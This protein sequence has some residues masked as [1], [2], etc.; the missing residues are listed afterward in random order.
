MNWQQKFITF[1]EMLEYGSH[2]YPGNIAMANL[3]N[4]TFVRYD[5]L[6]YAVDAISHQINALF[7]TDGRF[8]VSIF[9]ENSIEWMLIFLSAV[10]G[11]NII[12]PLNYQIKDPEEICRLIILADIKAV[13]VAKQFNELFERVVNEWPA[14]SSTPAPVI[15]SLEE[16]CAPAMKRFTESG[17]RSAKQPPRRAQTQGNT[18]RTSNVAETAAQGG[19]LQ[20]APDDYAV[21]LFTSGSINTKGV[22][23]SQRSILSN[24]QAAAELLLVAHQNEVFIAGLPLSHAYGL[25]CGFVPLYFGATAV[26]APTPRAIADNITASSVAFP[27][28]KLL[29][30]GV[31]ELARIMNQRILRSARG[32]PGKNMP[33]VR[34]FLGSIK[35]L[36]FLGMRRVNYF[37]STWFGIDLSGVFFK[38]IKAKFG[39]ELKIPIG[40]GPT[41]KVTEF[42]LRGVGILAHGGYGTTEMAP[43]LAANIPLVNKIRS[44]SV[45][46]VPNGMEVKIIDG[47]VCG[48]GPNMMLGY[49]NNDEATKKAMP[50]D[51]WYHTGDKGNFS[52][53]G[54]GGKLKPNDKPEDYIYTRA[55]DNYCLVLKGRVDNQFANHRGENIY[56]EVIES[57]LLKYPLINSCR[58]LES[59]PTHVMAHVFPDTEALE[60]KYGKSPSA[61][62]IKSVI[63][64]I[65]K[66]VN[67]QLQSGCQIDGFEIKDTDFDR[68][69][70]GKIKRN[71]N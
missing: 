38:P 55:D 9:S 28:K 57:L 42:G 21:L 30:A 67:L 70:F 32:G 45:G 29:T 39:N 4:K 62:T 47:E 1:N 40:G 35:Y 15:L 58:V 19:K 36:L 33:P 22:M 56:P 64:N 71:V 26:Y 3:V 51:G 54:F 23:H 31:P 66:Q 50:G 25:L 10:A 59:P 60:Q 43:L 65:V 8:V 16:A 27:D 44:G 18:T 41:D 49:L 68:N 14:D 11:N 63:S 48:R 69:A 34:K 20:S 61:E 13:Y 53:F 5:D 52:K 46:Q 2:N 12:A 6:A 7:N 24:Q 37:T 17:G